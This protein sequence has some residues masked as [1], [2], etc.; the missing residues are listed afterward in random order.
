MNMYEYQWQGDIIRKNRQEFKL[1]QCEAVAKRHND[2]IDTAHNRHSI[3]NI[4]KIEINLL[5]EQ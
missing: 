1:E 5:I 3:I 2:C 4:M